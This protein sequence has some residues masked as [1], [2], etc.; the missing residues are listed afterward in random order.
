MQSY[1]HKG[2]E[3]VTRKY[4][5]EIDGTMPVPR[6]MPRIAII[7]TCH[8]RRDTTVAS[9]QSLAASATEVNDLDYMVYLTDDGSTDGTARAVSALGLPLVIIEGTGDLFWNRGMVMAW[10]AALENRSDYDGFLLLNDD[11]RLDPGA[12]PLILGLSRQ[13]G[14]SAVVVGATRDPVTGD[15]TYGGIKRVS[16][17]HPGRA[18]RLPLSREPQDADTFNANCVLV[19][20]AVAQS[21][22]T[23]DPVFHHSMGDF[24]YGYRARKH[25]IR[26]VVAPGTVATC[27]ANCLRDAWRDSTQPLGRRLKLLSSPKGLPFRQWRVFLKRHGAVAPMFLGFNA[28]H[29]RPRL[30][31]GPHLE[32]LAAPERARSIAV[33]TSRA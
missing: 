29:K 5:H 21:I 14:C 15:V 18:T 3:N 31:L 33:A 19:P 24:D 25:R 6:I 4:R 32:T 13:L 23:L 16:P 20:E 30:V 2:G 26:V 28:I 7:M 1:V 27:A 17:W 12:L 10:C 8:N 22:G 9:L 11:T